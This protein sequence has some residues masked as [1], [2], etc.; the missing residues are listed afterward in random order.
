MLNESELD[1]LG[2]F[3]VNDIT[4]LR[5][6]DV[7]FELGPSHCKGT[8]ARNGRELSAR[9]FASRF[10]P[11]GLVPHKPGDKTLGGA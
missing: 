7:P 10:R 8:C 3:R 1:L 4:S 6:S 9:A 11:A 5:K 2:Q